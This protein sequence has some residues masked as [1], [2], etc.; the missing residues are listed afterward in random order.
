MLTIDELSV[1][2][3]PIRALVDVSVTV[4]AH[5]VTAI[6]GANGAGKSTLLNTIVGLVPAACGR[7]CFEGQDITR[8]DTSQ[9][10]ALGIALSP[11]GRRL[12][13]DMTV[14]DNLLTGAY[15]RRDRG[16]IARD[17]ERVYAMFPGLHRRG[18]SLGRHL[19]GGEQQMCAIG[20]ALMAMPRLLLLDEPSLG[21][22]PAVVKDVARAVR[23]IAREGVAIMLVEQNARLALSLSDRGHV[24]ETGRCVL[25]APSAALIQDPHVVRAY[26]GE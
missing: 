26:L 25:S 20:R 10:S 2:Y 16:A 15:R 14:H 8:H 17:L 18:G 12:F 19:S 24:F 4:P 13:P 6:V 22:S 3:G 5:S 1:N 9:R 23:E 11:E 21:L 7:V